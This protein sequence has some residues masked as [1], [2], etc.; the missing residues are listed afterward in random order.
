MDGTGEFFEMDDSREHRER[1]DRH[2]CAQE[3]HRLDERS[4][5]W[6]QL[7]VERES[8]PARRRAGRASPYRPL[9]TA[10]ELFNLRGTMSTRNSIPTT[11]M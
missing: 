10:I 5:L 9:N 7:R 1:A 6:K 11:N 8:K 4:L 3:E 2:G